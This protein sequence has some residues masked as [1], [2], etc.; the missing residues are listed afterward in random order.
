MGYNVKIT[1]TTTGETR[2]YFYD[3]D[4]DD[5]SDWMWGDGNYSCDCNRSLMFMR[6][7]GIEPELDDAREC[8]DERYRVVCQSLDGVELYSDD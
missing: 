6:A 5:A 8:G 4:W 3:M 1:D 7:T 2:T